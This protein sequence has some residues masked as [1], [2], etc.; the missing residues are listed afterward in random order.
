[1]IKA[2]LTP[3][4][5]GPL[6]PLVIAGV[7]SVSAP[8]LISQAPAEICCGHREVDINL[9]RHRLQRMARGL[10]LRG[11]DIVL[12]L[13]SDVIMP[14]GTAQALVAHLLDSECIC[15]AAMTQGRTDHVLTACAVIRWE[16]YELLRFWDNADECQCK[17]IA[18]LGRAEYVPGIF[19]SEI[20]K[21]N[22]CITNAP[23]T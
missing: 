6:D 1:M 11:S 13:D 4:L 10:N 18:R 21:N 16:H 22:E 15:S 17:K 20:N 3:M 14:H 2:I 9:N 19:C 23:R 12:L 5:P 7:A 8:W